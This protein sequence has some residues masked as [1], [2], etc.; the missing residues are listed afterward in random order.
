MVCGRL[1]LWF[2]GQLLGI[3]AQVLQKGLT[4]RK[5]E[6]K[7]E[8]VRAYILYNHIQNQIKIEMCCPFLQAMSPRVS[9]RSIELHL[10]QLNTFII[11]I[12]CRIIKMSWNHFQSVF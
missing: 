5:I 11:F 4:H 8:E 1:F 6:A 10:K 12:N 2:P 3:P 7:T 9:R